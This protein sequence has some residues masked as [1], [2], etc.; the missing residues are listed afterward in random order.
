MG[1]GQIGSSDYKCDIQYFLLGI[2]LK[3]IMVI[4]HTLSSHSLNFESINYHE[5]NLINC[6]EL[7]WLQLD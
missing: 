3:I 1:Y 4:S 2:L 7:D 5:F 6:H